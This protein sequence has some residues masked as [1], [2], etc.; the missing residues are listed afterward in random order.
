MKILIDTHIWLWSLLEPKR[1]SRRVAQLLLKPANEIWVSPISAWEILVLCRKGRL[2]LQPD[3][4]GWIAAALAGTPLKEAPI[5]NEVVMATEKVMLPHRDP[6]DNFLAAS[7]RT[8]GLT[9]I[10]SDENL[11]GGSGYSVLA[12]EQQNRMLH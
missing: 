6:A 9:L 5:T 12:N 8:Y 2:V 10:T 3:A 1:L 7:A 4:S 11:L